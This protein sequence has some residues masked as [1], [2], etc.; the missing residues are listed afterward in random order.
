MTVKWK[1][2]YQPDQIIEKIES[3]RMVNP[4]GGVKFKGLAFKEYESILFGMVEFTDPLPEAEARDILWRS[5]IAT[6]DSVL[7]SK[8][9][10]AELNKRA[11]VYSELPVSRY[12]LLTSLSIQ[13]DNEINRI[14]IGHDQ[15]IFGNVPSKFHEEAKPLLSKAQYS[16]ITKPPDDYLSVRVYV[17]SRSIH[18]A[19]DKALDHLDLIRAIWN[20][21]Y[22]RRQPFRISFGGIPKPINKIITGPIHTLH[23]TNG[24][25]SA[26]EMWWYD[27]SFVEPVTVQNIHPD[28]DK[29]NAFTRLVRRQ[30]SKI[31]YSNVIEDALRRYGRSLDE[32]DWNN[33]YLRLWS[34]L[35]LL[36]NTL[37]E[38]YDA[39]IR[40][41]A[42]VFEERDYYFQIL[43]QL[44]DYR[45][46]FVHHGTSDSS[47]ESYMYQL[48][49][50]VEAILW[51][52]LG[53][54]F[55]FASMQ[56]AAEFM[57][58]PYEH[59]AL[60]QRFALSANALK[61]RGYR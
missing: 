10:L 25:L 17:T 27:P 6:G 52:H 5:L 7:T 21:F 2:G 12:V 43:Q 35:E 8:R 24:E 49:N 55:R 60:N 20:L 1:S 34:L 14:K 3:I 23:K 61:F 33:A 13:S 26:S 15:L 59:K 9:L 19:A 4:E 44:R 31:C 56:E 39:T 30:L 53:N 38:S 50:I 47:I 37:H 48:K 51:F 29:I 32:R 22:N 40:R 46:S 42:F 28:F 18:E 58:L 11:K 41:A 36:T 54:S 57:S 16:I 45:N